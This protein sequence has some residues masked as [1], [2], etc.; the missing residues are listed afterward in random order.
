ML[1]STIIFY[2]NSLVSNIQSSFIKFS[3]FVNFHTAG[4]QKFSL[5]ITAGN[6]NGKIENVLKVNN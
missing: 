2:K 3:F 4:E 5:E 1:V 6:I